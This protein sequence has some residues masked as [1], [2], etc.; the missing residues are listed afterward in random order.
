MNAVSDP[1]SGYF[2]LIAWSV[3]GAMAAGVGGVA[4]GLTAY[5]RRRETEGR[6]RALEGAVEEF[7]SALRTRL[8]L[9]RARDRSQPAGASD[10]KK[11]EAA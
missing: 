8:D 9:G 6:L 11:H 7:C 3:A 1:G 10:A 2:A 5:R 4:F